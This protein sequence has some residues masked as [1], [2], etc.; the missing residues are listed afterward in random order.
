MDQ[1]TKH[2][3]LFCMC[4][5]KIGPAGKVRMQ[6]VWALEFPNS[7]VWSTIGPVIF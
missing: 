1:V 4:V 2:Y 5:L 3:P 6:Y 7:D